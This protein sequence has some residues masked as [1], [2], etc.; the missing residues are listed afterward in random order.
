VA[1][2]IPRTRT[3]NTLVDIQSPSNDILRNVEILPTASGDPLVPEALPIPTRPTDVLITQAVASRIGVR[4]GG[5]MS[6]LLKRT[7]AGGE[8]R[9]SLTLNVIGIV[10]DSSY[11]R[12]ALFA[13]LAFLAG[14]EDYREGYRVPVF[15]IAEGAERS[16][17]RRNYAGARLYAKQPEAVAPLADLL[18]RSGFEVR[19][20]GEDLARLNAAERFLNRILLAI[21]AISLV[22]GYLSFGGAIWIAIDRKRYPL[23]LLQLLGLRRRAI[24]SFCL[25][26]GGLLGLCAFL[27]SYVLFEMGATLLNGYG[28]RP[29]LDLLGA[30]HPI[31]SVCTLGGNTLLASALAT[32]AFSI[33]ASALGAVHAI[34]FQPAQCL[35]EI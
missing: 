23:A 11:A 14:L 32:V 33:L 13:P 20:R 12:P 8:R 2:L 1:F 3:L 27:V 22:G 9:Q 24:L 29:F 5:N 7:L 18:R 30:S 16:A 4:R 31:G 19:I 21:A 34:S 10:P 6:A 15:D 28:A 26:Q 35:R 25:T 17:P